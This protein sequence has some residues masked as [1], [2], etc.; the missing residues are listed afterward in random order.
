M[1]RE[2]NL[3]FIYT[4]EQAFNTLAAYGNTRIQ[5]PN[6]DRLAGESVLFERAYVTQPACTPSRSSLLT[7]LYPHTNGC[8]ENNVPLRSDTPCLP[9]ML[10]A[11]TY[12]TGHFGKW[13]LGDEL[14]TQ[15]GF[16]EWVSIEDGYNDRFSPGLDRSLRS[17]YHNFL[18]E[19]GFEPRHGNTFGRAEAARLPEA[20]SKPAF[21]AQ[22][23]A[24][25]IRDHR[26]KPFALH[27]NFLE[28]HMPYFGPRDEQHA[29]EE[30]ILPGNFDAVPG[31]DQPLKTRLLHQ[32][33][34][35]HGQSGLSVQTEAEWRR[36]I[37]NYWG[38]CSLVDTHVGIILEALE[39]CGLHE[40]TIVVFTSDHGDMMGSH[41][42]LAKCVMFEESVRVP[43]IIRAPGISARRVAAPVGQIDVVPTVLDL[44]NCSVPD[45]VQGSSLKPI[46][47]GNAR[48]ADEDVVVEW[49]GP[50]N[51]MGDE[52]GH[53]RHPKWLEELA[54][55]S[56]IHRAFTDPVRTIISPDG[57]KLNLSTI[58]ESEL[59]DLNED[60][61]ETT[62]LFPGEHNGKRIRELTERLRAWQ[63]RTGDAVLPPAP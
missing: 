22:Q 53:V 29:P 32:Y 63:K 6:L 31:E 40:N 41:R 42:L 2:P 3:L 12:T 38:L 55:T 44:M 43:L 33:Y 57:W 46:M 26:R 59:Y 5:M 1:N 30:V 4:D 54:P 23:A 60:P 27:V 36:M 56:S 34:M 15:H 18:I 39:S 13:H 9:E 37:A 61:G 28:P 51:G 20:F 16:Q 58:G 62:N 21:L 48:D 8:N 19:H 49:N 7:G 24:R 25:F 50:N 47:M 11:E 45:H 14:F 52:I 17:S 35:R 10:P